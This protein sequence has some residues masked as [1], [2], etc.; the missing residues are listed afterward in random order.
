MNAILHAEESWGLVKK[1]ELLPTASVVLFVG[2]MV[3]TYLLTVLVS[4]VLSAPIFLPPIAPG[5]RFL[6]FSHSL[7]FPCVSVSSP[8]LDYSSLRAGTADSTLLL[9]TTLSTVLGIAHGNTLSH[10]TTAF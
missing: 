2:F 6:M 5:V 3:A 1:P 7:I 9:A 4:S 10:R 8:H